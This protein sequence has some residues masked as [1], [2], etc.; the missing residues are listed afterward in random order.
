MQEWH[1]GRRLRAYFFISRHLRLF[2]LKLASLHL[3]PSFELAAEW[4]EAREL[5]E[6]PHKAQ[7]IHQLISS[8]I[9]SKKCLV[10]R[11]L[12]DWRLPSS[13][14]GRHLDNLCRLH[15]HVNFF[16]SSFLFVLFE[17]KSK[18][19]AKLASTQTQ[20]QFERSRG[21]QIGSNLT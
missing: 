1:M 13:K 19:R 14:F 2:A 5:S 7:W 4:A 18:L 12:L 10:L 9:I 8:N 3:S 15:T 6:V 20:T 16:S 11:I 17:A 21:R